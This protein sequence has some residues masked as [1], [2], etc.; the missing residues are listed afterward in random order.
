MASILHPVSLPRLILYQYARVRPEDCVLDVGTGAGFAAQHWARTAHRV[1]GI[2]I[3]APIVDLARRATPPSLRPRLVFECVDATDSGYA[4]RYAR[5][6]DLIT[7]SDA[8]EHVPDTEG[9]IAAIGTMLRPGGRVVITFPNE[10]QGHGVT[11]FTD[12]SILRDLFA[13]HGISIT[14]QVITVRPWARWVH[15][16]LWRRPMWWFRRHRRRY[17]TQRSHPQVMHET[18]Y[19]AVAAR[20]RHSFLLVNAYARL[21]ERLMCLRGPI[22]STLP[23]ESVPLGCDEHILIQSVPR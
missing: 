8:L 22:Y 1:K 10:I 23:L 11:G 6:F 20:P 4:A 16:T 13:R 12:P 3:S 19:A 15:D 14:V 18:W 9:F 2:D 21:V 17:T 7:S 5:A